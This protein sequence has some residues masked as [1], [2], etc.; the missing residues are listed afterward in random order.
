METKNILEI[1]HLNREFR[2]GG[3]IL[4]NKIMAVDDVSLKMPSDESW[5]MSIVGESGSGKTTLAKMILGLLDIS[6]GNI[7]LDGKSINYHMKH[8]KEFYRIVQP[9]FQNPFTNFSMKRT[10]DCYLYETALNMDMAKNKDDAKEVITDTLKKVGLSYDQ[11]KNKYPNQFSGGELQRISIARALITK[12]KIIVADEPVAMIDASLRM[13][14]V[15][16]FKNLKEEY[17]V[18][19]IYITHDLSTAYYVSDYIATMYKGSMIEFGK[20]REV[21]ENPGHPYTELL[22]E[23]IPKVGAKW[24]GKDRPHMEDAENKIMNG[25]GCK[26]AKRCPYAKDVC[27]Q[28]SLSMVKLNE[29]HKTLCIKQNNYKVD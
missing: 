27:F 20:A 17:G 12:P 14:I 18:S 9:I 29:S 16:I 4:G 24:S 6:G 11:V 8:K 22:L 15:N 5:I 28:K 26:F 3:M 10:V 25:V 13:N 23:S 21:L 19:F 7:I 2:I 1:S